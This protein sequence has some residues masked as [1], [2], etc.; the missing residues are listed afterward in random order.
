MKKEAKKRIYQSTIHLLESSPYEKL[1][2]SQICEEA[3]L[4]RQSFYIYYHSKNDLIK[5][6]YL[7]IL[8]K[9]YFQ[10]IE[11]EEDLQS[12]AFIKKVIDVYDHH[13]QLFVSLEKWY[14]LDYLTQENQRILEKFSHRHF[15]DPFINQ[16]SQYYL[17]SVLAPIHYIMMHWLYNEKKESK[18]ELQT[19]IQ[20]FVYHKS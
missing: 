16:Y 7:N 1:T 20:R 9:I 11:N 5:S 13:S 18:K 17:S 14:V 19:I 10:E 8:E 2:I 12:E 3:H 4:S 15:K 6:V